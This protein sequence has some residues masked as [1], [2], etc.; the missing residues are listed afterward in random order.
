MSGRKSQGSGLGKSSFPI[1]R[2]YA[3]F[4]EIQ[5]ACCLDFFPRARDHPE[6]QRRVST[7][8]PVKLSFNNKGEAQMFSNIQRQR[9]LPF[10]NVSLKQGGKD[11]ER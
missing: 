6:V 1:L 11:L 3:G 10:K 8:Y 9:S 2:L 5:A 7:L 4:R